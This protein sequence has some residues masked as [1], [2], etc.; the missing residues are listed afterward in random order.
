[1]CEQ[2]PVQQMNTGELTGDVWWLWEA[3]FYLCCLDKKGKRTYPNKP[4][5]FIV[6]CL[7]LGY[8]K[9]ANLSKAIEKTL[10]T[11]Y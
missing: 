6:S 4:T 5:G 9:D 8:H 2:S 1:M 11:K 10:I 7:L 3:V